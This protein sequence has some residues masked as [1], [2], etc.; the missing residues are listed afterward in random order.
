MRH[1][2]NTLK[3]NINNDRGYGPYREVVLCLARCGVAEI[4]GGFLFLES[5]TM[6]IATS[7]L[8]HINEDNYRDSDLSKQ[9]W[10]FDVIPRRK[11]RAFYGSTLDCKVGRDCQN[12]PVYQVKW[13]SYK[14]TGQCGWAYGLKTN[15]KWA[16]AKCAQKWSDRILKGKLSKKGVSYRLP[17][18]PAYVN[19]ALE[20]G[21]WN[22]P[23]A[24]YDGRFC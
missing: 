23:P 5:D 19:P 9:K 13:Y 11:H 7:K 6:N 16:C 3:L 24:I 17:K 10:G 2:A 14:K 20:N 1:H 4:E 18:L 8:V 22:V 15:Y 21:P 12:E